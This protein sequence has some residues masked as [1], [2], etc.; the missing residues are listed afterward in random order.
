MVKTAKAIRYMIEYDREACTKVGNC[1]AVANKFWKIADDNKADLM[2]STLN[3][4]RKKFE[5]VIDKNDL[6]LNKLAE[7]VCPVRAIVIKKAEQS[8]KK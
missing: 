6:E 8:Q 2:G 4:E 5:L 7:E 3:N 1:A